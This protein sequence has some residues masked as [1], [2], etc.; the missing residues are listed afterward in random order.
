MAP[1]EGSVTA[2][3]LV[4][5][6]Y[7]NARNIHSTP[8]KIY[9]FLYGH[10]IYVVEMTNEPVERSFLNVS[11]SHLFHPLLPAPRIVV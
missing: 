11:K 1:I 8:N 9:R 10:T 7:G 2:R 5:L 6:H 3:N 4:K